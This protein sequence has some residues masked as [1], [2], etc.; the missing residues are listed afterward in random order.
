MTLRSLDE[1]SGFCRSGGILMPNPNDYLLTGDPA[2][3]PIRNG[4]ITPL[5]D[6]HNYFPALAAALDRAHGSGDFI[7]IMGWS[8]DWLERDEVIYDSGI[9]TPRRFKLFRNHAE[10]PTA[11]DAYYLKDFIDIIKDKSRAGVEVRVMGWISDGSAGIARAQTLAHGIGQNAATINTILALRQEPTLASHCCLNTL[12]HVAGSVHAKVVLIGTADRTLAFT[13]GIDLAHGRHGAPPHDRNQPGHFNYIGWHDIQARVEGAAVQDL[14]DFFKDLWNALLARPRVQLGLL[15]DADGHYTLS[16]YLDCAPDTTPIPERSLP[17]QVPGPLHAMQ[18]LRTIPQ[19]NYSLAALIKKT[20]VSFAAEGATEIQRAWQHAI[21]TATTYIYIEDQF[22]Y[23]EDLYR[24]LGEAIIAKPAL[25]VL[26]VKGIPDPNDP[27]IFWPLV[28]MAIR[29]ELKNLSQKQLNQI[30]FFVHVRATVHAK[31]TL[32]DDVWA[33]IGSAN[34][35]QRSLYTD[36]EHCIS[37]ADEPAVKAYR[38]LLWEEHLSGLHG[39]AYMLED[40][41]PLAS[42]DIVESLL[43]WDDLYIH[44]FEK[45]PLEKPDPPDNSGPNLRVPGPLHYPPSLG[46]VQTWID[47]DS[48]KEW[49]PCPHRED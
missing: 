37:V 43:R 27:D 2:H 14:Y 22:L 26:L 38:R 18:S 47:P 11:V 28:K 8:L 23:S 39:D 19:A 36:F 33:M 29:K 9:G 44:S 40:P 46:F 4:K 5:I 16:P 6:S 41:V 3:P 31:T 35:A 15:R 20:A 17:A 24:W 13:G 34:F 45:L 1:H 25:R 12:A 21:S 10:L 42:D 7:Y 32:I 30:G 49:N 48:R